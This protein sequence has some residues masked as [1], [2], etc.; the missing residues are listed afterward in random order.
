[1]VIDRLLR[2]DQ[3]LSDLRVA[4]AV[5]EQGQH[6]KLASRQAGRVIARPR[7]RPAWHTARAP[8]A[9]SARDDRSDRTSTKRL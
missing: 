6:L 2:D 4:Q 1:M 3:T 7:A 5:Y 9:Q 8:L